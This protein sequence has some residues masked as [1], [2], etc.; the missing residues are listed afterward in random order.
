M[1]T[2]RKEFLEHRMGFTLIEL[3]VVIAIIAIIAAI[4]FPAF[5]SAREK[6]RQ[7]SCASNE[8]QLGLAFLQYTQDNDEALP[9]VYCCGDGVGNKLGGWVTYNT[10][11]VN[12]GS[13]TYD[14]TLGSIYP[15][16]KSRQVYICPDDSQGRQ[17]GDSYA[18]NNC[19]TGPQAGAGL[20]FLGKT[21]A[22]FDSP[23]NIMLLGEEAAWDPSTA[24]TDDAY[25][26]QANNIL[27]SR[28][29]GG[30][31]LAMVDGHV[32]WYRPDQAL[33]QNLIDPGGPAA[34]SN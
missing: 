32:K 21:L 30:S 15:Y 22:A 7:I 8:R 2:D 12:N 18:V 16:V 28:H 31:N 1:M 23:A 24:S 3:L 10:F 20:P 33:S 5:A 26:R 13:N 6:A 14:V 27:S 17:T 4:L 9:N 34:C 25:F 11:P 19:T 29:T